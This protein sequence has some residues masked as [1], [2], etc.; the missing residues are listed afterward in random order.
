M[1]T[2]LAALTLAPFGPAK[3]D[4]PPVR[5]ESGVTQVGYQ[6]DC[7]DLSAKFPWRALR[8]PTRGQGWIA[9]TSGSAKPGRYWVQDS[10]PM[11]FPGEPDRYPGGQIVNVTKWQGVKGWLDAPVAI[12]IRGEARLVAAPILTDV[13]LSKGSGPLSISLVD[14][15]RVSRWTVE[16]GWTTARAISIQNC[17]NGDLIDCTVYAASAWGPGQ[18]YACQVQSSLSI[19][20]WYLTAVSTRHGG[21]IFGGSDIWF[22]SCR[23]IYPRADGF[24]TH[25]YGSR[26]VGFRSCDWG[27]SNCSIGN[28]YPWG[29][30]DV[31]IDQAAGAKV[32][33]CYGGTSTTVTNSVFSGPL[34]I[35][36]NQAGAPES[37]TALSCTFTAF[38]DG[39]AIRYEG[40]GASRARVT[41]QDVVQK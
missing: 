34:V 27:G 36:A 37:V 13:S 26:K 7:E 11:R 24:E 8:K 10:A 5:I 18:G 17:R 1:I 30:R 4:F 12:D 38:S 3:I 20:V 28:K 41:L 2:L 40:E 32:L 19:T 15:F 16:E 29:D 39:R 14:G 33:Y 35:Q 25:G 23:A 6:V 21:S 9:L 22:D 31:L